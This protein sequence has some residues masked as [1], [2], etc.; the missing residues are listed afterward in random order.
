MVGRNL[1][2]SN[3]SFSGSKIGYLIASKIKKWNKD[4]HGPYDHYEFNGKEAEIVIYV[5]SFKLAVQSMARA[6]RLLIIITTDLKGWAPE[7]S[8]FLDQAVEKNLVQKLYLEQHQSQGNC[9]A[10]TKELNT[11]EDQESH[12]AVTRRYCSVFFSR[13]V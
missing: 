8:E 9:S 7:N 11:I 5:S 6:R 3:K 1:K 10:S 2:M 12:Y 4:F 13:G